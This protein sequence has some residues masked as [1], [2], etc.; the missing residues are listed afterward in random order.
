M[1]L[2]DTEDKCIWSNKHWFLVLNLRVEKTRSSFLSR[3]SA[4]PESL[5][6]LT[7]MLTK[8][9][10]KIFGAEYDYAAWVLQWVWILVKILNSR[11]I[12]DAESSNIWS[13]SR[14]EI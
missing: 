10:E 1:Q 5:M 12:S 8:K 6:G 13:F 11:K 9:W 3:R 4:I 14:R 7:C 2:Y